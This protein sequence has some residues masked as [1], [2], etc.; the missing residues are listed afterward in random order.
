MRILYRTICLAVLCMLSISCKKYLDVTPDNVGTIDYAFR[1]RNEAENFLFTCYSTM[2][3]MYEVTGN[4]GFTGSAEIVYPNDLNDHPINESGFNLLRGTQNTASPALNFWDGENNGI[5]LFNALRRCNTMLENIDKPIDLSA[6]EKKRWI[7]EVKFLKAYYHYYLIRM[8]GP[9]LLIKENLPISASAEEVKR[10][11]SST[12]EGFDYVI[13]LMDEA[14]PDLPPVIQNQAKELG[15]VT[16]LIALSVKAEI[17][18]TVASPLFNGNPD[19]AGYKDNDGKAL[20]SATYDPNKWKKA[21]DACKEALTEAEAQ[22]LKLYTF[23]PPANISNISDQL[24]NVLTIQATVTDKWE[25]NPEL[26]WAFNYNF[27]YQGY[28]IPRLTSKAVA[29]SSS[30]PSTFAVPIGT[31]ELFYTKNGVPINEDKTWDYANR[32]TVQTGD[33]ENKYYIKNGY[34]T[35]KTNFARE[36]RF[37]ADLGFDG[38]IWFGNGVLDQNKPLYVQARGNTAL[39]GPKSLTSTNITGYWPKKLANYLSIYDESFQ[40][41]DYHLPVI[42]LAGLYLLYAETLNEANGPTAEVYTYIDKVRTRAGL[43]GVIDSWNNFSKTPG[44]ATTKEGLRQI[45]HQERR[46]ELCF[47]GQAGWDL[48][49]WKELQEVLS[50]PVQGWNIYE[51]NPVN[52]YRPQTL[53]VPLFGIKDYLWPIKTNDIIVN[54]N[55]SQNPYW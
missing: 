34:Q 32:N 10:K 50:K 35:A 22:G 47:E 28:T 2:Q 38:G 40:S 16:K 21:A 23:S 19:Y 24:K 31:A 33:D 8:Y 25:T 5:A 44:K 3:Q 36:T 42:R 30:Y 29:I 53:F 15:R 6:T 18:A 11:R 9:M 20:F 54:N 46:I 27:R 43:P 55:L 39:A 52:Y 13:S 17:L 26:I 51:S 45:I 4:A 1:N 41:I 49:R 7:A 48:R 14:I 37:Y 12:D